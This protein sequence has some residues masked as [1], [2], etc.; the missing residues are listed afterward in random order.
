VEL[1]EP[2]DGMLNA[3]SSMRCYTR[4]AGIPD[5]VP[6]HIEENGYPTAPPLRTYAHQAQFARG[7]IHT[8]DEFRGTFNVTDYRWF[9]LRDADTSSRQLGQHYGLMEDDYTEKPAFGAYR[10]LVR[11]LSRR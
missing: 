1:G 11:R 6:M 4:L 7:A 3:M 8:V 9:N 2:G 10:E 5:D